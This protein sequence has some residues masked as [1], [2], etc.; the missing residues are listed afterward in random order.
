MVVVVGGGHT[1]VVSKERRRE[2]NLVS[3]EATCR[4]GRRLKRAERTAGGSY[5][6]TSQVSVPSGFF[7]L[8]AAEAT[9]VCIL[10]G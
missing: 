2:R 8:R 1:E 7:F 10:G 5:A 4:S 6:L 3:P 9:R